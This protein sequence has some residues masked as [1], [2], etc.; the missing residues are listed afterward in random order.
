M[1]NLLKLSNLDCGNHQGQQKSGSHSQRSKSSTDWLLTS[2]RP[3]SSADSLVANSNSD[4]MVPGIE[5]NNKIKKKK[6]KTEIIFNVSI[7]KER[8]KDCLFFF[9]F[10]FFFQFFHSQKCRK[11]NQKSNQYLPV[12]FLQPEKVRCEVRK[13]FEEYLQNK[14]YS[15]EYFKSKTPF[16]TD[17]IK[18]KV[19]KFYGSRYE[20]FYYS[21]RKPLYSI[22]GSRRLFS[23]K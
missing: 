13:V 23:Y 7:F 16:L 1:N 19:K 22:A 8:I 20:D 2:S 18:K 9:F 4:V 5:V 15:A 3:M 12:F 21:K 14:T 6:S 10:S 11:L 17:L